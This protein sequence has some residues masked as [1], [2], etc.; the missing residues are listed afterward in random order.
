MKKPAFI[1]ILI[2]SV[3]VISCKSKKET[4]KTNND[5]EITEVKT[6]QN[7]QPG[8]K[9]HLVKDVI[10]EQGFS[11]EGKNNRMEILSAT[12]N[13]DILNLVVSYSGGCK[14][15]NLNLYYTG[16]FAKSLPPQIKL[17]LIDAQEEDFCRQLITDTLLYNLSNVK[18]QNTNKVFLT[19]NNHGE[20]IEYIY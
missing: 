17:H 4:G 1:I 5:S 13:E 10:I 3:F 19:I 7:K 6:V 14:E 20:K 8:I 2:L 12:I 18:V 9:K 11:P 15:H 16:F